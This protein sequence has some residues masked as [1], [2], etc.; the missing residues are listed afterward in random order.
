MELNNNPKTNNNSFN[1]STNVIWQNEQEKSGFNDHCKDTF[2]KMEENTNLEKNNNGRFSKKGKLMMLIVLFSALIIFF[3]NFITSMDWFWDLQF[4]ATVNNNEELKL[5]LQTFKELIVVVNWVIVLVITILSIIFRTND[6]KQQNNIKIYD[7]YIFAGFLHIFIGTIGLT[8]IIYSIATLTSALENKKNNKITN[9][10]TKSDNILITFSSILIILIIF[11]FVAIQIN[12]FDKIEEK[13]DEYKENKEIIIKDNDKNH[14]VTTFDNIIDDWGNKIT[15]DKAYKIKNVKLNNITASL[16]IDYTFKME[17]NKPISNI[18]I[19]HGENEIYNYTE[20]ENYFNLSYLDKY[21][22]LIIYG[23]N[24]CDSI[25][26]EICNKHLTYSQV[27]AFNKDDS[28]SIYD[29]TIISQA[30]GITFHRDTS[31]FLEDNNVYIPPYNDFRVYDIKINNN[32][33]YFYTI[34]ENYDE[35]FN[36]DYAFRDNNCNNPFWITIDFDMQR[37]FKTRFIYNDIFEYKYY[38][39]DELIKQ[40][41]I[42]YADYCTNKNIINSILEK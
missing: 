6:K 30:N 34:V 20:K 24:Y 38:E 37:T 8:P 33:I 1:N 29:R 16:Y 3:D 14:I 39:L 27:L 35:I 32:Y 21:D 5:A 26:D 2:S 19:K 10:S 17:N 18:M 9:S 15:E 36:Q 23:S 11:M 25:D 4:K 7:W 12:L 41:S 13:I 31:V 28:I 42:K 40:S 22:N